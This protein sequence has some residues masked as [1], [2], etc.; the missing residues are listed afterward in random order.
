MAV[1][2][3]AYLL[4]PS[5][6]GDQKKEMNSQSLK[7]KTFLFL[8]FPLFFLLLSLVLLDVIIAVSF[9]KSI[10]GLDGEGIILILHKFCC[11][12]QNYCKNTNVL[13]RGGGQ[14]RGEERAQWRG[15]WE[16][17]G[18]W[19]RGV[20]TGGEDVKWKRSR[21]RTI[22]RGGEEGKTVSE[23]RRSKVVRM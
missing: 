14:E 15:G 7:K 17:R 19:V 18:G 1:E 9:V 8:S 16:R 23:G 21:G 6:T 12:Y 22:A 5:E 3:C 4:R 20:W 13:M 11:G 2:A 10:C